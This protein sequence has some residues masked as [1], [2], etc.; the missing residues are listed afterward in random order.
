MAN[1]D[2]IYLT[3]KG[4]YSIYLPLTAEPPSLQCTM[5]ASYAAYRHCESVVGQQRRGWECST[6]IVAILYATD[7]YSQIT[8]RKE[9]G[10]EEVNGT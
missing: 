4:V 6:V 5:K 7:S 8:L 1:G 9:N 2:C 3:V 10:R